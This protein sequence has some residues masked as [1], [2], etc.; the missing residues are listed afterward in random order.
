M[1]G[2]VVSAKDP[3]GKVAATGGQHTYALPTKIT[4]PPPN[5]GE[6]PHTAFSQY[7]FSTG[8]LTGF[9]DR[10]GIITQTIYNDKFDRPTQIKTALTTSVETHTAIYYAPQTNPFGVTLTNNDVLTAKDQIAIDD[11]TLR[12]WT[13]TD[14]FGRTTE[15]WTHAP[16]ELYQGNPVSG[17]FV[18]KSV[19]DGLGRTKS[20]IHS[21]PRF[22]RKTPSTR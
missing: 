7:D 12:S 6:A 4:S 20:A 17:D 14:G 1:L 13:K 8:L 10:N 11:S 16:D 3:K 18:V 9:K 19:Y 22:N 5:A 2:N 21:D 15:S